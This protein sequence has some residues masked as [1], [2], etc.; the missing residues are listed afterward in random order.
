MAHQTHNLPWQTL[1]S[2]FKFVASNP[3]YGHRTNLFPRGHE[4][5]NKKLLY[6]AKAFARNL[7][8]FSPSER[9][10]YA[11]EYTAPK[12]EDFV[13]SPST[14][15]KIN[16][17]LLR[18]RSEEPHFVAFHRFTAP[19]GNENRSM[20]YWLDACH[21]ACA[22][23]NSY[24]W[25]HWTENVELFK[26]LLL[27]NEMDSIFRIAA[28]PTLRERFGLSAWWSF[29]GDIPENFGWSEVM[30]CA[31]TSYICLN[32][33][34]LKPETH[35]GASEINLRT[36]NKEDY[37]WTASYQKM[38]VRCTTQNHGYDIHTYPH[39][40]FFGVP[41]QRFFSHDWSCHSGYGR[42]PPSVFCIPKYSECR[43]GLARA[44]QIYVPMTGEISVVDQ[45]LRQKG[46]PA[47]LSI[48]VLELA[49]YGGLTR[50]LAVADDP[51]HPQNH[52]DLRKYLTYC[53]QLLLRYD[54]LMKEIGRSINWEEEVTQCI[55][56]LWGR[57][58]RRGM[59]KHDPY[60]RTT[61]F[62]IKEQ[63]DELEKK[64]D[65]EV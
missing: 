10:K 30:R 28:H 50:R 42:I 60:D 48:Q 51:L 56:E 26:A 55:Y 40:E 1:A 24:W 53:W 45:Y 47:E 54:I 2:E 44:S 58:T 18:Y 35:S 13:I 16:G 41:R 34:Y 63:W 57:E 15:K 5:Q 6:F 21:I 19:L 36:N 62:Y 37:R 14:A 64:R 3:S 33:F 39:R 17:T 8:E 11:P 59:V 20:S 38:L 43:K 29:P 12:R 23:G 32:V 61:K 27:H 31:L 46:L 49:D 9:A 25:Q 65:S 4:D 22:K 7:E 52:L